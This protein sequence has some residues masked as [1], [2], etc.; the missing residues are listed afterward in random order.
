VTL[1]TLDWTGARRPAA[2]LSLGLAWALFAAAF[3]TWLARSAQGSLVGALRHWQFWSLEACVVA[4][5][6]AA[7]L[8]LPRLARDLARTDRLR[9]AVLAMSALALTVF[10][11]PRTNRIFYDEQI[12]QGIAQNLSD[13]RLAQMCNDGN[14][15]YGRL[16]CAAGEYNKQPYAFP[17]LLSLAYRAF[18][19]RASTPFLVN[20]IVA[21]L[22][23]CGVYLLVLLLFEDRVAAWFASLILLLTPQQIIWSATG[24][25]EP[26]AALACLAAVLCAAQFRRRPDTVAL[27]TTGVASAYAVQFRPESVLILPVV[28]LLSWPVRRWCREP[29]FW[30]AALLVGL[31]IAVPAAHLFAVRHEGWGTSGDRLSLAYVA[32]NLQVNL[33]FYLADWRFPA[34]FSVLAAIGLFGCR[35]RERFAVAAWFAAFF[36]VFLLF[37]AGSYDFGAD[38]RYSLMTDVPLA[39]LSGIGAAWLAGWLS[40]RWPRV[41]PQWLLTS[42]LVFTFLWYAPLVRATTEEAWA[43]R[44]DVAFAQSCVP[45]LRGNAYVLTHNPSIFHVAGVNAGQMSRITADPAFLDALA[46]RYAAGVYLHWNFW[47]NIQEPLQQGFCEKALAAAHFELVREHRERDQRFALYRLAASGAGRLR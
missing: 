40:R 36:C 9:M 2:W 38:V 22:A 19:V 8:L 39:V 37:Y 32:S 21:M 14:V 18:G 34:L 24:A 11:A 25:V 26:S 27:V 15:E 28:A 6:I 41:E 3:S 20:A 4:A 43:A 7:I 46:R 12:Y 16:D 31:L 42:A 33:R 45:L 1:P 17:H 13:L 44:A 23:T 47:C 5:A 35:R 10:V 30:G 29:R